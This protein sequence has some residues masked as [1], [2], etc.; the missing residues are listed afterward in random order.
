MRVWVI[1]SGVN[2]YLDSNSRI[3]SFGC[4]RT[5]KSEKTAKEKGI[6]FAVSKALIIGTI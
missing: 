5:F 2:R 3:V 4:S 6:D 1:E